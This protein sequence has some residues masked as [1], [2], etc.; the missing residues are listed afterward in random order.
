MKP[1]LKA[2]SFHSNFVSPECHSPLVRPSGLALSPNRYQRAVTGY[3]SFIETYTEAILSNRTGIV[4]CSELIE[5]SAGFQG[6]VKM[7]IHP[8]A[9]SRLQLPLRGLFQID[10]S[11]PGEV[12]PDK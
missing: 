5:K 6:H 2:R 12:Q 11:D 8:A 3:F 1:H 10:A 4:N 7:R 9:H